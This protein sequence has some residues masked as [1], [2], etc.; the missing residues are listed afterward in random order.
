MSRNYV[1]CYYDD[2]SIPSSDYDGR[3]GGN[4]R[5]TEDLALELI[6]RDETF[7]WGDSDPVPPETLA[8]ERRKLSVTIQ[9]SILKLLWIAAKYHDD[10]TFTG[11]C[12]RHLAT[13]QEFD[14]D[15]YDLKLHTVVQSLE[16]N[17][18]EEIPKIQ[19]QRR[20]WKVEV[21]RG[22]FNREVE[23]LRHFVKLHSKV[24]IINAAL[25]FDKKTI[26]M[27]LEKEVWRV[28]DVYR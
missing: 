20:R 27:G 25:A 14:Q 10:E 7:L 21:R 17:I 2:E 3:D 12:A 24:A 15:T 5:P 6:D 9:V 19:A 4:F 8:G 22:E 13:C 23:R 16:N 18:R 11:D 1:I 26:E 28:Y